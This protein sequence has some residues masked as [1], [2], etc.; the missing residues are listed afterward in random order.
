MGRWVVLRGNR[1]PFGDQGSAGCEAQGGVVVES[2]P[3]AAPVVAQAD[4]LLHLLVIT[5]VTPAQNETAAVSNRERLHTYESGVELDEMF[6]T[7]SY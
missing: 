4:L 1:R 5:L 3:A 7:Q 2:A 6:I